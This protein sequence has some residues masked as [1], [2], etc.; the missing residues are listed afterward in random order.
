VSTGWKRF[1]Q[2]SIAILIIVLFGVVGVGIGVANWMKQDLP[3]PSSLQTIAPPVKTLVYDINGK[4]VHEFYKENRSIVPLRQIPRPMVDAIISIE[5]RRFY[6][7]WGID[8]VRVMGALVSDIV[9]RR[10]AEGASTITQQL[11]RNLFLTHEKTVTRKIKEAILAI[12]IEQTYT[13]DEILEMY[14]NQI[15][16]GEGAYGLDAAAKVF[17]GKQ[18]QQLTLPECA[19][20]F[21]AFTPL[22]LDRG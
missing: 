5:D 22:Y 6:T 16:F 19:S 2:F 12:R 7:H 11:A 21:G 14:F 18:V 15:Y 20:C 4:L 8:P 9:Q 3:S 1:G 10:A 17:F 13:K